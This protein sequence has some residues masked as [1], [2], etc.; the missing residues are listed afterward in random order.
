MDVSSSFLVGE[1][2]PRGKRR[3]QNSSPEEK[4]RLAR[5]GKRRKEKH[6]VL[7]S[8]YKSECGCYHCGENDVDILEYH[9]IDPK[10]KEHELCHLYGYRLEK[11]WE[12]LNKCIVVCA[13]C[14]TKITKGE[15][16][17]EHR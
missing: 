12:E 13:N 9:H 17:Y 2:Q 14:H 5:V 7:I 1:Q 15:K 4:A 16:H 3:Y 8:A 10:Q 11:I 6:S